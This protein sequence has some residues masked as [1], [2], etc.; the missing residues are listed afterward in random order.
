M[1]KDPPVPQCVL[2][3]PY[4]VLSWLY[5]PLMPLLRERHGTRIILLLPEG[6]DLVAQYRPFLGDDDEIVTIPD[7]DEMTAR[8][9][10]LVDGKDEL[11]IARGYEEKYGFGLLQDV[12]QQERLMASAYV[13][14]AINNIFKTKSA[15]SMERL[16]GTVNGYFEYFEQM[17]DRFAIDTALIWPRS[18]K[19]TVGAIV[20]S[21]RGILVTYPY[22]A[23][24]KN[25]AYWASGPFASG[26]QH[27]RA[28][29]A[30]GECEPIPEDEIVPP[31]RPAHLRHGQFDARYSFR[32]MLK[33][34]ARYCFFY[35]EFFLIDLKNG[36][37][38]NA[39]RLPMRQML[40]KII[41]DWR[42]YRKFIELCER[43]IGRLSSKPYLFFAF[44]AEPEFSVQARCKEFNDQR[45]IVRQ[46]SLS[47]P[48]DMILV[49]KEHAFIGDRQLSFYEDLAV[50]PNV[51]MAHPGIRALDLIEKSEAVASLAGTVTLEAALYGKSA[52][53]F[54][55][56]SE[57]YFL[58]NVQVVRSFHEVSSQ[59]RKAVAPKDAKKVDSFK[60][61][62]ARL[63]KAIE[64]IGVDAEPF[65]S[66]GSME[67]SA[68]NVARA[69]DLLV[70]LMN[71]HQSE[72]E[73]GNVR[74]E[75]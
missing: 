63:R 43:D 61:G 59:V 60:R 8:R 5:K 73:K 62:G 48:A 19:E 27:K 69:A 26:L 10:P 14:G 75:A 54:T 42:Y 17:F 44:Q 52:L 21:H 33:E 24:H 53:I 64:N 13:D 35:L 66:K 18:A 71:L 58:P 39:N 1:K 34:L 25:F 6:T 4:K 65:Y 40:S 28:Y 20:A 46:L 49:I 37:L 15:P 23:K 57:F 68:D 51:I 55:D 2:I 50:L 7:Y 3:A 16:A 72:S 12:I 22:T 38:G 47:L 74:L 67:I 29:D 9:Q 56:R 11:A 31:D 30:A 36:R 32:G 41:A 70:D 45:A